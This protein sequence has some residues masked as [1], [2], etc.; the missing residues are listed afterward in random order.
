MSYSI[1][2]DFSGWDVRP[3]DYSQASKILDYVFV[4][5]SEGTVEDDLF[6]AQWAAGRGWVLRSAYHFFRPSVALVP[7]VD[8]FI[9]IL[10]SDRGE[11]APTLDLEVSDGKSDVDIMAAAKTWLRAYE[12]KTGTRPIVYTS[13]SFLNFLKA[14]RYSWLSDYDL[15][16]A[17]Y[18]WE[19]MLNPFRD[20][21]LRN[22]FEGITAPTYPKPSLPWNTAP[23]FWQ[24]T[25]VGR[26]E[27]IPGYYSGTGSKKEIDLNLSRL[28]Q[29][30]LFRRYGT[31]FRRLNGGQA[32]AYAFSITPTTGD[33]LKVRSDHKVVTFPTPN[34]I[35]SLAFGRY[36][37]GNEKWVAP[38][39]GAGYKAGD[40]WLRVVSV[41][42]VPLDGW[43]AEIHNGTKVGNISPLSTEPTPTP[44]PTPAPGSL[45]A[46]VTT[47]VSSP[48]YKSKTITNT[49]TLEPE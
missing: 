39:D 17:Q 29:E 8:K 48:G 13:P 35:G 22:V 21:W 24:F 5:A 14:Y 31:P 9:S 7:A 49:V 11:M 41:D 47:T 12:D 38:S 3:L 33:G 45:E 36:A 2:A 37:F 10:G 44:S 15:W 27:W 46:T 16:L 20:T 18:S 40:T 32:M 43:V 4:K 30:E 28:S 42:G 34:Q 19:K 6:R 1:G 26:P 23:L 25:A